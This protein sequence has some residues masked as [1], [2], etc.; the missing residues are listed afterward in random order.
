MKKLFPLF[1]VLS[2]TML[3]A[4]PNAD[5]SQSDAD[6]YALTTNSSPAEPVMEK[7]KADVSLIR[8][9]DSFVGTDNIWFDG[10]GYPPVILEDTTLLFCPDTSMFSHPVHLP[11]DGW[12][13]ATSD[14]GSTE[15]YRVWENYA[16]SGEICDIHWWGFMLE[17]TPDGSSAT[18]QRHSILSFIRTLAVCPTRPIRLAATRA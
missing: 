17:L 5:I 13:A 7:P 9:I 3:W 8:P 2:L 14:N 15:N 1:L 16:I 18:R 11:D 4:V 12:S 6:Y 10:S